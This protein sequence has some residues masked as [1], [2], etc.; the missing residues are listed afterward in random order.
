MSRD[1]HTD[2]DHAECGG[3][4]LVVDSVIVLLHQT[5]IVSHPGHS[6]ETLPFFI[7]ASFDVL[8]LPLPEVVCLAE[9]YGKKFFL[10]RKSAARGALWPVIR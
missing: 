5:K 3:V 4:N 9:T 1:T 2:S 8:S 6:A 10:V 7:S